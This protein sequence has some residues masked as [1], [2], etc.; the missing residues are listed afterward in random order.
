MSC[1]ITCSTKILTLVI[2]PFLFILIDMLCKFAVVPDVII[3]LF[4]KLLYSSL[5]K[6]YTL[7]SERADVHILQHI[8]QKRFKPYCHYIT[9]C[10]RVG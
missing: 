5:K 10:F 9:G 4:Y 2:A 7:F 1:T 3:L 8:H 6:R